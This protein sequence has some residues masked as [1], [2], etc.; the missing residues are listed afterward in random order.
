MSLFEEALELLQTSLRNKKA[1][2]RK[3]QF[4]AI[5]AVFKQSKSLVIQKTGWGKSSVYFIS[6]KINRNKGNGLSIVIS[7]LLTL[8]DNQIEAAKTFGLKAESIN[9]TNKDDHDSIINDIKRNK[10]DVLFVTPETLFSKIRPQLRNIKIGMIVIDEVHCISDWGHDFRFE[11]SKIVEVLKELSGQKFPILATTATANDRVVEDLV[12]QIGSDLYVSKGELYRDNLKIQ[13]SD[14][15]KREDRYAW[16][17][18]NI[19]RMPGTGIIYCLTIQDCENLSNFLNDNNIKAVPF[20]SDL[21]NEVVANNISLFQNNKIKA[22]V[23]TIKLGMGYDKNDVSFVIHYQIPKNIVSYY[24]QIGRAARNIKEGYVVLLKGMRDFEILEY[25]VNNAFPSESDMKL[26]LRAFDVMWDTNRDYVTSYSILKE[27][28][29]S[30]KRVNRALSF[31]EHEGFVK[32]EGG[33]Y[34]RTSKRFSYSGD[35]YEKITKVRNC[36]LDELKALFDKKTCIN[37]TIL[38]ALDRPLGHKCGHCEVCIGKP[39]FSLTIDSKYIGIA[40]KFLTNLTIP[41][42][43]KHIYT[44]PGTG[45]TLYNADRVKTLHRSNP[46]KYPIKIA[47]NGNEY[48]S[49][50]AEYY[51]NLPGVCLSKYNDDGIGYL[52]ARHKKDK[53]PYPQPVIDKFIHVAKEYIKK[54]N[55]NTLTIVPSL[56]NML[57]NE[58]GKKVSNILG[59]KYVEFFEKT[60]NTLQKNMANYQHQR[61]NVEV[62]YRIKHQLVTRT[63]KVMLIDDM[64]DSGSTL[65]FLGKELLANGADLVFPIALADSSVREVDND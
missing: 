3:G 47:T 65:A 61:N 50:P 21:D 24:Q 28:N 36:E 46:N 58:F 32:R 41:I 56:N 59:L 54:Y 60:R 49:V 5:E 13:I 1:T 51:A 8:I 33:K 30:A 35:H 39:F 40:K 43:P 9:Y 45:I 19:N 15:G 18:Q 37:Q 55:I 12:R 25:F 52:V 63:M 48:V 10:V 4:E 7:P 17:L 57:M 34:Y 16:I 14:I 11:Y 6:T 42:K 2:F 53:I 64:A 38:K 23:S 29:I 26:I 22:I 62:S 20:H 44:K 31:L 27:N